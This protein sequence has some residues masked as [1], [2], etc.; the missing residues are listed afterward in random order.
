MSLSG[1]GFGLFLS[2]NAR[3]IIG[4]APKD[5]AAAT[6]GLIATTRLLGQTLGATLAAMLLAHGLATGR[7]SP[8]IAAGLAAV[9]G[10]CSLARLRP[11]IRNGPGVTTPRG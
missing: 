6:G 8:L 3:L 10:V 9:A 2:P 5:R 11:N 1:S 4:S 7:A